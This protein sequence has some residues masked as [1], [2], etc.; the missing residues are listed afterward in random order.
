MSGE[1]QF[2]N[3]RIT[4]INEIVPGFYQLDLPYPRSPLKTLN[5]YLVRGDG[6]DLLID[7]GVERDECRQMMD[8]DLEVLGVNPDK[9][10]FFITH[11]HHDHFGRL[12]SMLRPDSTVYITK[13]DVDLIFET[14]TMWRGQVDSARKNGCPEDVASQAVGRHADEPMPG[15]NTKF[16]C[17]K[18]DDILRVG[19]FDLRCIE[20]PG[21]SRGQMCLYEPSEKLLVAGDHILA[22]VSPV[23]S[24]WT[25]TENPLGDFLASLDKVYDLDVKITLP[26]HRQVIKDLKGRIDELKI[27]HEKRANEALFALNGG[28]KNAYEIAGKITWDIP[29][30]W[31]KFYPSQKFSATGE[32]IAH[33]NYLI[34]RRRVR[35]EFDGG[36]ILFTSD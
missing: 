30:P 33:L 24:C 16:H 32:T 12:V 3:S 22:N 31:E 13:T 25:D 28:K 9:I 29:V 5:V 35:R 19:K 2:N 4:L 1:S 26:G 18:Q 17:L 10:D 7:T 6:R 23:I 11:G 14:P 15:R 20:T 36:R 34:T 21:H 8:R 27:H